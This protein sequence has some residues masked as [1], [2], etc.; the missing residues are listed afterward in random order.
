[1]KLLLDSH[2][3]LWFLR[4]KTRLSTAARE[5]IENPSNAVMISAVTGY[6]LYFKS[7]LGKLDTAFIRDFLP[8][9]RRAGFETL[10]IT[11]DHAI[12]AGSL[13]GPHRD[14]WD[15]IL[16]AQAELEDCTLVTLD[17]VF[18]D[19]GIKTLW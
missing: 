17:A 6:E 14:P 4:G 19:Y 13:P 8:L 18:R 15:R 2:A 1:M 9:A 11:F 16:M 12:H 10:P 5:T 7:R 3:A